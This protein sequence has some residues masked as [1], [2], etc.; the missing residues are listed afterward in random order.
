MLIGLVRMD[1]NSYKI[2]EKKYN[3]KVFSIFIK[4]QVSAFIDYSCK[5]IS[6]TI[7]STNLVI[8]SDS[9]ENRNGHFYC[10]IVN[11]ENGSNEFD[12]DGEYVDKSKTELLISIFL[13]DDEVEISRT[14]V[15]QLLFEMKKGKDFTNLLQKYKNINEHDLLTKVNKELNQTESVLRES[16]KNVLERG[17][18]IEELSEE[19]SFM[20]RQTAELFKKAKKKN[21]CC[22][23]F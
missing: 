12:D 21:K 19:A 11:V 10:K 6:R 16:L 18:K 3:L 20:E 1:Q 2:I 7:E 8:I 9:I 14:A 17:K 22:W 23:F 13:T 4:N 5:N 15:E